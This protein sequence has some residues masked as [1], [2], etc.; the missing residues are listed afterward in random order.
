MS[1]TED[2]QQEEHD[3]S[4][5]RGRLVRGGVIAALCLLI[6]VVPDFF[7]RLLSAVAATLGDGRDHALVAAT[8]I[9][10]FALLVIPTTLLGATFSVALRAYTTN[11]GHVGSRTGNATLR[12]TATISGGPAP[13]AARQGEV[14][15]DEGAI[16][17]NEER[18]GADAE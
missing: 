15:A 10:S 16:R 8:L 14:T 13:R 4:R 9:A 6:N 3:E 5:R 2:F 11:V 7:G 12:K 1:E 18:V 17:A